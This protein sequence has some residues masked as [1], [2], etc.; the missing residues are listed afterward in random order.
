MEK[1]HN[2]EIKIQEKLIT[3][4]IARTLLPLS[5]HLYTNTRTRKKFKAITPDYDLET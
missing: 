3:S 4:F 2:T 5:D 1:K